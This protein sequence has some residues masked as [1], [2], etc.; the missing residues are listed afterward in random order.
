MS[1]DIIC[2]YR[3]SQVR[4]FRS[5]CVL[6]KKLH[7]QHQQERRLILLENIKLFTELYIMKQIERLAISRTIWPLMILDFH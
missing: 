1:I 6:K 2:F 5:M 3:G 7:E 4:L